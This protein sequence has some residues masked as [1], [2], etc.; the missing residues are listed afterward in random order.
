MWPRHHTGDVT[1]LMY[2]TSGQN[3][4]QEESS[5]VDKKYLQKFRIIKGVSGAKARQTLPFDIPIN[6]LHVC[7]AQSVK[8]RLHR[9]L[10]MIKPYPDTSI[11]PYSILLF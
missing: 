6:P 5:H 11:F 10:L 2:S 9:F 8:H 7:Y 3:G 1:G 4:N